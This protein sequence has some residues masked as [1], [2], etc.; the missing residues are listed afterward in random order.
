MQLKSI[1]YEYS[2]AGVIN[3]YLFRVL[4]MKIYF[5]VQV[6]ETIQYVHRL[7]RKPEFDYLE[8]EFGGDK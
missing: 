1:G 5:R 3:S 2:F 7:K 6:I 4:L 8:S